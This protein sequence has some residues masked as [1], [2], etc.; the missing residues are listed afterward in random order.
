LRI[1]AAP[2]A[3]I[4]LYLRL[5]GRRYRRRQS[6]HLRFNEKKKSSQAACHRAALL[7]SSP[8]VPVVC[9]ASK[10]NSRFHLTCWPH[11]RA[12]HPIPKPFVRGCNA[13]SSKPTPVQHL[14]QQSWARPALVPAG[15]FRVRGCRRGRPTPCGSRLCLLRR[16][17]STQGCENG[18]T[19]EMASE[20]KAATAF[21]SG[22]QI[23]SGQSPHL[24][25]TL[26]RRVHLQSFAYCG[27]PSSANVVVPKA[28]GA[29]IRE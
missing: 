11:P 17:C 4:W 20:L 1:A 22:N 16:C 9:L 3:P 14:G 21:G 24:L 18:D 10:R 15:S 26:Q 19:G 5:R 28:A 27:C 25:K 6:A 8:R 7:A 13:H 2:A 12:K 29:K 23:P